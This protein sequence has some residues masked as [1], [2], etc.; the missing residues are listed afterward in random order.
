[1]PLL[2]PSSADTVSRF[3]QSMGLDARLND[4]GSFGFDFEYSGRLSILSD[5]TGDMVLISLTHRILL[6]DVVGLA[7]LAGAA[8]YNNALGQV[9]QAGLNK[10]D[11]PVLTAAVMRREFDLPRLDTTF[12]ALRDAFAGQGL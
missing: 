6:E 8:G 1:M 2:D 12:S 5:E 10:A 9:L 4:D 7:R 11:Q 3:A